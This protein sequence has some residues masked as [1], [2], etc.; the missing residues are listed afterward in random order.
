MIRR[1]VQ[2]NDVH[3]S[4]QAPRGRTASYLDDVLAKLDW[5]ARYA[6]SLDATLV[7]TGDLFHRKNAAHTTHRT[8]QRVREVLDL[9]P[10]VY[11]VP[12]N[13]DAAYG[14]G[15]DGQPLR[16]V[17]SERV[18]LLDG[19]ADDSYIAGV[20]WDNAFEREGGAATLAAAITA[21]A[22]PL[23]VAHAPLTLTPFPFGPE[24]AGWIEVAEVA[25]Q[26]LGRGP[27]EVVRLV[28]HGHMHKQQAV[29]HY[30]FEDRALTFSNPG[31]LSRATVAAD[32]VEREPAVAVITYDTER[33]AV[34][35]RYE[36]V[37]HRPAAEVLLVA[38][39][40]ADVQRDGRVEALSRALLQ[41]YAEVV[42]E[43]AL[44]ELLATLTRP[45]E[46][47]EDSWQ[48]GLLLAGAAIDGKVLP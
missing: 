26:I 36:M 10:L 45:E 22:R 42:D 1:Y 27:G 31:A 13:H 41:S 24:A 44:H 17:L 5:C 15:L 40:A 6:A 14:G 30:A 35:V 46:I 38:E 16:S 47:P 18:S 39:H 32:D 25:S 23:V 12:G 8:V 48:R 28:A 9:A 21:A 37:P 3:L 11:I 19:A 34:E 43:Q 29:Q 7:I 20:P 4:D 2:V 33:L